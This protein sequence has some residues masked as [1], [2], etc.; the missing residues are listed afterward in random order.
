VRDDL[1]CGLGPGERLAV[2]VPVVDESG[3]RADEVGDGV[4]R[5]AADRLPGDEPKNISTMLSQDPEVG[6]KCMVMRGFCASQ[7][8]TLGCL[9][10]A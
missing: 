9:W 2:G 10:V 4:E 5:A 8:L 1:V 7:A 3:D 6:V